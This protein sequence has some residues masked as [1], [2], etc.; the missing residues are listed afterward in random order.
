MFAGCC[1]CKSWFAIVVASVNVNA[2]IIAPVYISTS[3]FQH[4]DD[5]ISTSLCLSTGLAGQPGSGGCLGGCFRGGRRGSGNAWQL[6]QGSRAPKLITLQQQELQSSPVLLVGP[7]P[8]FLWG[9]LAVIGAQIDTPS[10][11]SSWGRKHA[12]ACLFLTSSA[13]YC[14]CAPACLIFILKN[15]PYFYRNV[16]GYWLMFFVPGLVVHRTW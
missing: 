1:V 14:C 12:A 4:S 2:F 10:T 6:H 3:Q 7:P 16:T 5:H 8:L 15:K 13:L 9:R 11:D